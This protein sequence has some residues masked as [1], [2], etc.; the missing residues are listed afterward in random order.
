MADAQAGARADA[1]FI[2]DDTANADE[3]LRIAPSARI[4]LRWPLG[5]TSANG[6]SHLLEP[7][8]SL[9]WADTYG[10]TPPNEDSL[11]T[12]LD[13]ANLFAVSRFAGEDAVEIGTQAAAGLTWTRFGAGGVTSMLSFGRVIREQA[14]PVGRP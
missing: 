4:V 10:G 1:Y 3:D 11:R 8:I 12:E 2:S 5:Y 6:T 13:R 9:A 7:A 14:Q